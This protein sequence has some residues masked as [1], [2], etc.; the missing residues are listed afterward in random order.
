MRKKRVFVGP[1][2]IAG[3]AMYVAR[4]LG[5]V[6]INATSFSYREHPFGYTC[7]FDHI[8]FSNPFRDQRNRNL[9]QKIIFNKYTFGLICF[10]QKLLLFIYALISYQTFIFISHETFFSNNKDLGI[11][12]FFKKRIAFLFTG[13]PER[14][15]NDLIN[16][17]DRGICSFCMDKEKQND[18]KCFTGTIKKKR[19][20]YISDSAD[21]IFSHRDTASFIY[22][23]GKIKRFFAI[24]E[25][26]MNIL[27][28]NKKFKDSRPI[29]ITHLPSNKLLKGTET[30][31]QVIKDLL[32]LGYKFQYFSELIPHSAVG[33][34]LNQT[35][36]LI[37]QFSV[38]HG[39]L[40]LEGMANGCVTICRASQW[41]K[42][43]FPGLP[44]ISCEQEELKNVLIELISD[45]DRMLNIALKS[46]EYYQRYHTPE[47]VGKYYKKI[48]DLS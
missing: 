44:L 21:Y 7:D 8:L 31:E 41:F 28:I 29:I 14:D 40:G 33:K 10:I 45:P 5:L 11:L 16:M 13:C 25:T 12:R 39:L 22:D 6:G 15:P 42:E 43:D 1:G 30:T 35:H 20:K 47:V 9:L 19:I 34:V 24:A 46:F 26:Q 18:L 4:A 3:N 2:N 36:I 23:K 17:K 38:G 48:L 37:D 27:S 32:E